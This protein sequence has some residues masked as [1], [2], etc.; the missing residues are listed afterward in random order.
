MFTFSSPLNIK[1]AFNNT[2]I[3]LIGQDLIHFQLLSVTS[4]L[5]S[6]NKYIS[7]QNTTQFYAQSVHLFNNYMFRP[8]LGH[9]RVVSYSLESE[10]L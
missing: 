1:F 7:S 4:P 8:I 5:C 9:I 2:F 6:M 3:T 10:V